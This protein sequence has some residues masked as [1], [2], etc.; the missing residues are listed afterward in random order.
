MPPLVTTRTLFE[1]RVGS[2]HTIEV[3]LQIRLQD[4]VWWNSNLRD[5]ECQLYKLIGRRVLPCDDVCRAEIEAE[6]A[7][8]EAKAGLKKTAVDKDTHNG[9]KR[10][11]V[12]KKKGADDTAKQKQKKSARDG[13]NDVQ[14]T[15]MKLLR[16]TTGTW[17]MGKSI[18]MCTY[19]CSNNDSTRQTALR[20]K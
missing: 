8:K 7:A 19:E 11:G 10:R 16:A 13:K 5:H 14:D 3:L 6:R 20:L 12:G 4:I 9:R 15:K 18:Q 17:I 1:L 2:A